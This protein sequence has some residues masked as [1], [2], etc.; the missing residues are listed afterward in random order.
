M[1]DKMEAKGQR[2]IKTES[3]LRFFELIEKRMAQQGFE[4]LETVCSDRKRAAQSKQML[5]HSWKG[6]S[7]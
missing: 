4:V 1:E 3:E 7:Y 2:P 5:A 6:F